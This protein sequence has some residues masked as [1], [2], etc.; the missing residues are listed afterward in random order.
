MNQLP[1]NGCCFSTVLSPVGVPVDLRHQERVSFMAVSPG[2]FGTMR[3]P[4]KEGRPFNDRDGNGDVKI[5]INS[6]AARRYWPGRDPL[7]SYAFMGGDQSQRF[8]IVGLVGDVKN[9]GLA[10]STVPEVYFPNLKANVNQM[11]FVVR[12][13]L[14]PESLLPS[15]RRAIASVNPAQPIYEARLM[16]DVVNRSVGTQKLQSLMV[17]FFAMAALMMAALGVYGLIAYSVR[18]RTVEIGTRMAIGATNRDLFRLVVGDGLKMA[19]FGIG[20]GALA[21]AATS[22]ILRANLAGLRI[23]NPL[24]FLFSICT[25][26]LFVAL[27][28]FVPAW[29]ATLLSP[30]V[31]IRNDPGSIWGGAR[32]GIQRIV[33]H[34]TEF[35]SGMDEQTATSESDL[36]AEIAEAGRRSGSYPDALS[37]ALETVRE[38]LRAESLALFV[39][40]SPGLPYRCSTVVPDACGEWTLPA[41]ALIVSRLRH[42]PGALPLSAA[43]L[44]SLDRWAHENAPARLEETATLRE[45]GA[46]LV[47]RV[48]VKDEISGLLFVGR[49]A[50]RKTYSASERRLFRGV[51]AQLAMMLEN[52]RLTDRIVDQERLRRELLLAS[53]VQKRLFP[54][55]APETTQIELTGVCIP[56]RGVGGDYYDFL[57]LGK[58]HV[59]IAL[60]D[61]AGKG[62][63]AALV[64]SV[65]Q[66]SLRSL[67]GAA[68]VSLAELA[69]RMN[70]LL[71]R[72]T[73]SNSY[74]TFFYAEV[75]EQ[76][77]RLRYVNAGHNPPYLL[78]H[79]SSPVPFVASTAPIEELTTGGTIIGMFAQSAYEEGL[80]DLHKGDVL[81]VFTDGVPEALNPHDEEFGEE[82]LKDILRDVAHLSVNEMASRIL[83]NL[84]QWIADA[85][86][87]DDLTFVLM[88]VI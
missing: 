82:R 47:I 15:I 72:S 2:Y 77:G 88:K 49:P 21:V 27:A 68:G 6:A 7:G 46:V 40:R 73:R 71:H 29:R 30:M 76:T 62:I 66:A 39:Q 75:N 60:A 41:D 79:S 35:V 50:S 43:D 19:A 74:A 86:Q 55:H 25:V 83:Q 52:G 8:Q 17:S 69:S 9:N 59:G 37:A 78:R 57:D 67:A 48:A 16:T 51:A 65:V 12:A 61:V 10:E 87:Y 18:Q 42:Y 11:Y 81:I 84:K 63:A 56:A 36:L 58:H 45:T 85:E 33:G 22:L 54:E 80:L 70:R 4:L 38:R 28:C 24:P 32:S 1:M 14:P 34:V 64:M 13:P 31:A 5:I 23:D 26:A 3:I 44:D 53:E 20:I